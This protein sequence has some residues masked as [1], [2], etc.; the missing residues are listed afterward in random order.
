MKL[1]HITPET[2]EIGDT[3][4]PLCGEKFVMTERNPSLPVC[5]LCSDIALEMHNRLVDENQMLK[6]L[7][8]KMGDEPPV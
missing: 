6:L 5:R 4:T 8:K 2:S 7:V 3:V 1:S